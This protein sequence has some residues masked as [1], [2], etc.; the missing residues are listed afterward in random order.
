MLQEGS[1]LQNKEVYISMGKVH[2]ISV[3][4]QP[5]NHTKKEKV[6]GNTK[7]RQTPLFQW[8][9]KYSVFAFCPLYQI[10]NL[11][12]YTSILS[13]TITLSTQ[14]TPKVI[15]STQACHSICSQILDFAAFDRIIN[16][17]NLPSKCH[18]SRDI[19]TTYSTC[20]S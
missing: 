15:L 4:P 14:P 16:I 2:A 20:D 9:Y 3:F 12:F 8:F 1:F 18:K 5:K 7:Y 11:H 19:N 6:S 13:T 17:E 10:C